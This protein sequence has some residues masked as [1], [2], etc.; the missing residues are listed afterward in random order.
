VE[1]ATQPSGEERERRLTSALH[2]AGEL[3]REDNLADAEVE[4]Q[5]A[6]EVANNDLRAQ[7]LLGLIHFRSGRYA[8]ALKLFMELVARA[9]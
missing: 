3:L 2:R 8:Q 7:N 9:P 5:K 6:L 1:P 4:V